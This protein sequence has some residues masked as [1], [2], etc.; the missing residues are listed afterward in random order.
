M[1][2]APPAEPRFAVCVCND[3]YPAALELHKI[4][5]TVPDAL[6]ERY[7]L[8]RIVD[9]SGEGYLYPEKFFQAVDLSAAAREELLRAS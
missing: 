9:E 3:G 2:I 1:V 5:R 4:Y 8:V 7:G 6:A